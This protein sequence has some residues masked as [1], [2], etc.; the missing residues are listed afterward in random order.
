M[1]AGVI[2][3]RIPGADA[4]PLYETRGRGGGI[5]R[6]DNPL[7][8]IRSRLVNRGNVELFRVNADAE[9]LLA[10]DHAPEFDGRTF[11]LH[12]RPI[13]SGRRHRRH[14][15]R[16]AARSAS[17]SRSSRSEGELVP[18]AADAEAGR[19]QRRH[20]A[21]RR[22]EHAAQ[23]ERPRAG[24]AVHDRVRRARR[25][26]R[27]AAR[28]PRPTTHPTRSSSELPD[29]LPDDRRTT[30]PPRSP[31]APP[32]TTTGWSPS[33]TGSDTFEYS[34][35]VQSGHGIERDR[36]LPAD[37]HGLLRAVRGH[38][39]GDGAHAR[40]P[41]ARGRRL[42]PRP[43]ARR[44][45]V[46]RAR[47][48]TRTPGRRSG[49]TESAGWRSSRRPRAASPAPRATRASPAEQDTTPPDVD[50]ATGRVRVP[51]PGD[52]DDGVRPA[53]D[54]PTAA[55]TSRRS[56]C[57]HDRRRAG[58]SAA[59]PDARRRRLVAAVAAAGDRSAD[60]RC[61]AGVPRRGPAVEPPCRPASTAHSSASTAAWQRA[62]RAAARA[63]VDGTPAM[64]S[65]EW[66]AATA[67]QLPGGG[68]ADG[69]AGARSSTA[70]ST[71]VPSRS[72]PHRCRRPSVATASCGPIRSGGSP[73]TR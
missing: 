10:T 20:P 1:I 59:A 63:G 72:S 15:P 46:Q 6:V 51:L 40:H 17:R 73:P 48:A 24:R 31:P 45:L 69:L 12:R 22:H 18:A 5:T 71:R 70:S 21:Q 56:G 9:A 14:G 67:H 25:L 8:D 36:E 30:S 39:R 42:H 61:G 3:P 41:V 65:R 2:G 57:P 47:Q 19:P 4:D 68:A 16:A 23:D 66:A 27:R 13:D 33:R 60:R 34:T 35:E 55:P 28:A 26:D 52:A 58:T 43:A 11:R 44:R 32:P 7:V 64:T 49:S 37:P 38:V 29:D 62:C 54:D 53:D 50:G